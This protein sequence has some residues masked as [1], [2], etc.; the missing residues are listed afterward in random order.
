MVGTDVSLWLLVVLA[1]Q[2]ANAKRSPIRST[3]WP[4]R[5]EK[6]LNL[7]SPSIWGEIIPK[8]T[9]EDALEVAERITDAELRDA[10]IRHSLAGS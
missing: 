5:A 6:M 1:E 4:E 3:L 8:P 7:A 9:A 10:L 2:A